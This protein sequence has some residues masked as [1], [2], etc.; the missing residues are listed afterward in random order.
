[1]L[2]FSLIVTGATG[3]SSAPKFFPNGMYSITF[4]FISSRI[5]SI[6]GKKGESQN[7]GYE[8]T[9]L[10]KSSEKLTFLTPLCAHVGLRIRG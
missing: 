6:K 7:G 10:A 8:K 9:K 4:T 2:S 3:Y 5:L 1:M